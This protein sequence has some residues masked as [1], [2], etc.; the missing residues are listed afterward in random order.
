MTLCCNQ[1]F[2]RLSADKFLAK[3]QAPAD[4]F[5]DFDRH[6]IYHIKVPKRTGMIH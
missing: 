5:L 6:F 2:I 4:F 3:V 1:Y